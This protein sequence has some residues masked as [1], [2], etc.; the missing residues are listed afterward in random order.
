MITTTQRTNAPLGVPDAG[1]EF[2][3]PT[4]VYAVLALWAA[5]AYWVGTSETFSAG[6]DVF[7]RPIALTALGPVGI[8]LSAYALSARLRAWT[9]TIPVGLL[10]GLQAWRVIGFCF[11]PLWFFGILP[12]PFGLIAGL[13]DVAVGFGAAFVAYSIS[14]NTSLIG[15][16]AFYQVH[17]WGLID[18]AGAIGSA[19][20]TSGAV[21]A[22][23]TGPV[24]SHAMEVW[25]LSIFP[26]FAVPLFTILHFIAIRNARRGAKA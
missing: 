26:S 6:P 18:F 25:P 10:T 2:R 5:W 24:T 23:W 9:Y 4:P 15:G 19:F 12:G 16:P 8:F 7:F 21:P 1:S 13:G 22:V 20:L 11:L 17:V 14:K 3:I